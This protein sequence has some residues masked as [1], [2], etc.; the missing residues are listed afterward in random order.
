MTAS[1][2]ESIFAPFA[3][4]A[5]DVGA[6]PGGALDEGEVLNDDSEEV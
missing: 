1:E 3:P 2:M 4:V 5:S 6:G